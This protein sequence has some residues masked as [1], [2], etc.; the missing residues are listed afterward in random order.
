[1][2]R[3]SRP[4]TTSTLNR[5]AL[6]ALL[7]A[8]LMVTACGSDSTAND[9]KTTDGASGTSAPSIEPPQS[10]AP[11]KSGG[12][13]TASL[14]IRLASANESTYPDGDTIREFINQVETMSAGAMKVEARYDLDGTINDLVKPVAEGLQDGSIDIGMEF[15]GAWGT[16]GVTSTQAT[17][18]P[19]LIRSFAQAHAVATDDELTSGLLSGLESIG[20]KGLAIYPVD[21]RLLVNFEGTLT[22]PAD[23]VGK[24][25]RSNW[26][27]ETYPYL[28]SLGADVHPYPYVVSARD[29]MPASQSGI[30]TG[31]A[32]GN[33]PFV[34]RIQSI[35]VN[36]DF[37]SGLT[38]DQRDIISRAATAAR[39]FA[40]KD[41]T[42]EDSLDKMVAW[43]K[44]GGTIEHLDDAV[45]AV[46]VDAAQPTQER[47]EAD[48]FTKT[49]IAR[50]VELG[51]EHAP[52]I[53]P[54][55][56]GDGS[57]IAAESF[58][59]GMY[60]FEITDEDLERA[61]ID[62]DF[63]DD[64]RGLFTYTL[65][66]GVFTMTQQSGPDNDSE[67]TSQ[68]TYVTSD[69]F[70]TFSEPMGPNNEP[71]PTVMTWTVGEDQSLNFE[72]IV[73]PPDINY[74]RFIYGE[75]WIRI[76]DAP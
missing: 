24:S 5:R 51:A 8:G 34:F 63:W 74:I 23:L 65:K 22:S 57:T 30:P 49:A 76:G 39:D 9:S 29:M 2:N 58:P 70:V 43:C 36:G 48:P 50:I 71:L 56:S 21:T 60:R 40:V 6:W 37:W 54:A 32:I 16:Q 47:L 68:G 14:T 72:I 7:A 28:T 53:Y 17:Q 52:T 19:F 13:A 42:E 41:R 33:L 20:L 44:R 11:E 35:V 12:P 69:N 38:D 59:S 67:L 10:T 27:N 4:V 62:P 64:D 45:I 25:F 15:F 55:C 31:D 61:S 3:V 26:S 46:F 1:M 66:D 18:M 73:P 75:P